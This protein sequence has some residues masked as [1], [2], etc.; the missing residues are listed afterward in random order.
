MANKT[1]EQLEQENQI[2]AAH[3]FEKTNKTLLI[4]SIQELEERKKEIKKEYEVICAEYNL[5]HNAVKSLLDEIIAQNHTISRQKDQ[6]DKENKKA[7]QDL[8]AQSE[9]VRVADIKYRELVREW[10]EKNQILRTALS[11]V[12]DERETA[13]KEKERL[14]RHVSQVEGEATRRESDV[15]DRENKLAEDRKAL[16]EEKAAFEPELSRI[17]AIKNENKNL[18]DKVESDRAEF[19]SRVRAFDSYKAKLESEVQAQKDQLKKVEN[20]YLSKEGELR[21]WKE[22]LDDRELELKAREAE[23]ERALKRYQLNEIAKGK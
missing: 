2:I 15:L 6:F 8:E 17:T 13:R 9:A 22:D 11:Q 19:D 7:I 4:K 10:E 20:S 23:A 21:K 16:E 5:K 14:E 3:N 12:K 1:A 18:W